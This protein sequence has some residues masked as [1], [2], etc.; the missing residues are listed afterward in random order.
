MT[1]T[2]R[3]ALDRYLEQYPDGWSFKQVIDHLRVCQRSNRV[4][5]RSVYLLTDG[6]EIA[7]LICRH[8]S[9]LDEI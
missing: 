2:E 3:M 6:R 9:K 8:K 5:N 1:T 7:D 4:V